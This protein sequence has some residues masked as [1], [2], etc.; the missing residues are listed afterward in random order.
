[1]LIPRDLAVRPRRYGDLPAGLRGI[2][3]DDA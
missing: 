1:M 2:P 3:T